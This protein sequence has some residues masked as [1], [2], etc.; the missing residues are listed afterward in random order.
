ME[1]GIE[2]CVRLITK[3]GKWQIIEGIE[4]LNEEKKKTLA[5][6]ETYKY[7]RILEGDTIKQAELKEKNLKNTHDERENY[8][9]PN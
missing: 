3:S 2:T 6:K 9:K 5:E 1:F 7:L 8:S 4:L